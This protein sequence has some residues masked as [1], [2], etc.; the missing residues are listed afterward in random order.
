MSQDSFDTKYARLKERFQREAEKEGSIYLPCVKPPRPVDFVFIGMEPSLGRWAK[1]KQE[2]SD[3]IGQGF[4]DFALSTEDFI[5]HYCVR[6]YLCRS[7]NYYV[8]NIAKGAMLV[9]QANEQRIDRYRRWYPLLI[10]EME[11]VSNDGARIIAI[12][13]TVKHFLEVNSHRNVPVI[14]HYSQQAARYRGKHILG[15]ESEF[16]KLR[17]KTLIEDIVDVAESVIDECSMSKK[18]GSEI[19]GRLTRIPSLSE[20]QIKLI[21]DYRTEFDHLVNATE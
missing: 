9:K 18:L 16:E 7:D 14:L 13:K 11:L 21:F 12:G 3:K 20:S 15:R 4:K 19:L 10:R 6:K 17:D 5:L 8:T 1:T 2:A